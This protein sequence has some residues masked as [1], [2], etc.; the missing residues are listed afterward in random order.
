M[1][2]TFGY[3][4]SEQQGLK[5]NRINEKTDQ[6]KKAIEVGNRLTTPHKISGGEGGSVTVKNGEVN[7]SVED[8][9]FASIKNDTAEVFGNLNVHGDIQRLGKRIE[10]W[11]NV[12]TTGDN[13][14]ELNDNLENTKVPYSGI[15]VNRGDESSVFLVYRESSGR[16]EVA[17]EGKSRPFAL[18]GDKLTSFEQDL[19]TDDIEQGEQNKYARPIKTTHNFW[20]SNEVT[21]TAGSNKEILPAFVSVGQSE[22]KFVT[23]VR[24]KLSEGAAKVVLL[25][26]RSKKGEPI[27]ISPRGNSEMELP[28]KDGDEIGIEITETSAKA[29]NLSVSIEITRYIS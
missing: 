12:V 13:L 20:V 28:L 15:E 8:E 18:R 19:T 29:Q 3:K 26:N 5:V 11:Q 7:I 24:G 10:V 1:P 22:K 21:E 4:N 23:K 27:K 25:H 16:W 2:P 17:C 9:K 6:I 14:I